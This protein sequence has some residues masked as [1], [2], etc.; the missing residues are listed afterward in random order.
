MK[1]RLPLSGRKES[2]KSGSSKAFGF[3]S[4]QAYPVA[5]ASE[6]P[7]VQL[8]PQSD[9]NGGVMQ[10]KGYVWKQATSTWEEVSADEKGKAMPAGL[11]GTQDGM[12]Y[13]S[14][15]GIDYK[16]VAEYKEKTAAIAN[17]KFIYKPQS[18]AELAALAAA[19][20]KGITPYAGAGAKLTS[21]LQHGVLLP[22]ALGGKATTSAD[23]THSDDFICVNKFSPTSTA[24]AAATAT[25]ATMHDANGAIPVVMENSADV[26]RPGD[27]PD[28]GTL[29]MRA[30]NSALAIID[31][32]KLGKAAHVTI[33]AAGDGEMRL[34]TTIPSQCFVAVL[35]PL[36]LKPLVSPEDAKEF[37][38][39]FIGSKNSSASYNFK[40]ENR[41]LKSRNVKVSIPDY[42]QALKN[43]FQ[44]NPKSTFLTHIIRLSPT[45]PIA[46]TRANAN[47]AAGAGAAAVGGAAAAP[48]YGSAAAAAAASTGSVSSGAATASSTVAHNAAAGTAANS[49][50]AAKEADTKEKA[51]EKSTK[52]AAPKQNTDAQDIIDIAQKVCLKYNN[53]YGVEAAEIRNADDLHSKHDKEGVTAA[54]KEQVYHVLC[55][56]VEIWMA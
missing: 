51:N 49:K 37:N 14:D 5:P 28:L 38:I 39:Q 1:S 3:D 54:N 42:E 26:L 12:V 53:K 8:H 7:P 11:T 50:S 47:A 17:P 43:I 6:Q 56:N 27:Q 20:E 48:S 16:N 30:H 24:D 31:P 22:S 34:R 29:A 55:T 18:A 33:N 35:I 45:A 21:F 36:H 10:L 41:N 9:G 40:D 15:T 23:A 4:V 52:S 25:Y 13:D 19:S 44:D 2:P 46:I 32:T